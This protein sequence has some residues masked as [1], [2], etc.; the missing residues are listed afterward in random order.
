MNKVAVFYL[1]RFAEGFD[2]FDR[3]ATSYRNYAAGMDHDLVLIAK[4]FDKPGQRAALELIFSDINPRIIEVSDDCGLDI[5]AYRE[6]AILVKNETICFLNTYTRIRSDNWL[7]KLHDNFDHPDVGIVGATASYESLHTSWKLIHKLTWLGT[8]KIFIDRKTTARLLWLCRMFNERA[9]RSYY[10]RRVRIRQFL[11]AAFHPA[12]RLSRSSPHRFNQAWRE[13]TAKGAPYGEVALFPQFPNPHI[14]S[15]GF[16]VARDRFLRYRLEGTSKMDCCRFESGPDSLTIQIR[17]DGLKALVVGDNGIGYHIPDWHRAGCF[18]T[19]GQANRLFSDNQTDEFERMTEPE[20]QSIMDM[21]WGAYRFGK[22]P[23]SIEILGIPFNNTATVDVLVNQSS[24]AVNPRKF[25][26]VIP[27]KNR[28]SLLVDSLKTITRQGYGDIEVCVFD[29]ASEPPLSTTLASICDKSIRIERSDSPLN[30]TDSWNRA[31][32]MATGDYITLIG[33]DDAL[34]PGY[35]DRIS[36]LADS[37]DN[38]DVIFHSLY[39]FIHPGVNPVHREGYV[40]TMP[41]A[42]FL[43]TQSEPFIISKDEIRRSVDNSLAF[44]RSFFFNMPAFVVR[45]PFLDSIRT[46]GSVFRPAFP[47]YYFAN[48]V[49]EKANKAIAE[50]RSLA[51]Q[52]VSSASF[53][54]TLFND[55]TDEGFTALGELSSEPIIEK[56]KGSVIPASRYQ[57]EYLFTMGHIAHVIGDPD[58]MPNI[59]RY[60]R[61]QIL[62]AVDKIGAGAIK[63]LSSHLSLSEKIWFFVVAFIR[64]MAKRGSLFSKLYR[65]IKDDLSAYE[66][67]PDHERLDYGSFVRNSEVYN[68]VQHGKLPRH[69]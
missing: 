14:R 11:G 49:L 20:Q 42:D 8:S 39:Q 58:R 50:P 22:S 61:I 46:N 36:A 21:S 47:D 1:A 37:F 56:L 24:P 33:D 51:L 41:M 64:N 13:V 38:P 17:R 27:C 12:R 32:D 31:I 18:R 4:G 26:V 29:N 5:H 66:F 23:R 19:P 16:M 6:A 3:F 52:G 28:A 2:A 25:S 53:G 68:A 59:S 43:S 67:T 35:F 45:K 57:T 40:S 48:I 60:R 9:L 63:H 55:R 30:V 65:R 44:R 62:E 34:L 15:N 54:F 10:S 69:L 7:K